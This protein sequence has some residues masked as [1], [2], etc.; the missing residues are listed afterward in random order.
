MVFK[1]GNKDNLGRKRPDMIGNRLGINNGYKKGHL[2]SKETR[3][4]ISIGNFKGE[5]MKTQGYKQLWN[6]NKYILVSH[7]NWCNANNIPR[8][9]E[10]CVV[11]PID[12]DKLNNS[13]DNLQLMTKDFHTKL[14]QEFKKQNGGIVVITTR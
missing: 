6:G 8:V 14:H 4:K 7:I 13:P 2:V 10:G 5:Q 12:L 11:H 9:P 1:K 3:K